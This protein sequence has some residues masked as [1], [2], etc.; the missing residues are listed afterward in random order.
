M[1][2]SIYDGVIHLL[3]SNIC[4][5]AVY[6]KQLILVVAFKEDTQ[7]QEGRPSAIALT[8]VDHSDLIIVINLWL[9]WIRNKERVFL[10]DQNII[11]ACGQLGAFLGV[12]RTFNEQFKVVTGM[13]ERDDPE[14]P[15]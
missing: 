8:K 1:K 12:P 11:S 4:D 2:R 7:A 5:K 9:L 10:L 14:V 3:Y 13:I 6:M 15:E